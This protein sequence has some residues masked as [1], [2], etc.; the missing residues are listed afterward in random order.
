MG[1]RAVIDTTAYSLLELAE[2]VRFYI[3][4]SKQ[5]A[6]VRIL[7]DDGKSAEKVCDNFCRQLK[8]EPPDEQLSAAFEDCFAYKRALSQLREV[9]DRPRPTL[10]AVRDVLNRPELRAKLRWSPL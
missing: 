6:L 8:T 5:S 4:P 7:R 10:R 1:L 2:R 9:F 3:E